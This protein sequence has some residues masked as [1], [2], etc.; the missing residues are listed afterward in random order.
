V[1]LFQPQLDQI[2]QIEKSITQLEELVKNVDDYS[3][4]LGLKY[5]CFYIFIEMRFKKLG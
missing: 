4:L 1:E 3:K 5:F 2:E